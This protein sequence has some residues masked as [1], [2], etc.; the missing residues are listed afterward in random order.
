MQT[1]EHS[2][3][4]SADNLSTKNICDKFNQILLTDK[5]QTERLSIQKNNE[6]NQRQEFT[7]N[8]QKPFKI[9]ELKR[10]MSSPNL[11]SLSFQN[12]NENFKNQSIKNI[13]NS[14]T[15]NCLILFIKF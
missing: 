7:L 4:K 3:K 1:C 6:K 13:N 11:Q 15:K 12:L 8:E 2:L 9:F 5:M 14:S 10:K